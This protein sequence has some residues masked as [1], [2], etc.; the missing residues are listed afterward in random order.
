MVGTYNVVWAGTNALAL[1][2]GGTLV[3]KFGFKT[4]FLLPLV[5]FI[6]ELVAVLWLEKH[7]RRHRQPACCR[8]AT[9]PASAF[10]GQN[11]GV[12]PHG[13]ARESVRLHRH[14]HVHS[15]A[16][17]LGGALPPLPDVR[18]VC[19][20]VVVLCAARHIRRAVAL[21]GL[22]LPLPLAGN[23]V[24]NAHRFVCGDSHRADI[25]PCCCWLKFSSVSRLG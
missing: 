8:A 7:A 11:Q 20:L 15:H 4:L 2:G 17:H 22:A 6:A 5:I 21:D 9:R 1:F 24:C 19:V 25:L 10:A 13:V 12:S 16:A 23:G 3:E 18:R 14:Q